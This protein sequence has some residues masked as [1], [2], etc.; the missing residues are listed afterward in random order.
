[1]AASTVTPTAPVA[2]FPL[3]RLMKIEPVRVQEK[4]KEGNVVIVAGFQGL[5]PTQDIATLGR[6]GSD[7][8]AVALAAALKAERCQIFTDVEGVYTTDPRIVEVARKLDEIA[9]D[10][11]LELAS[12]GAKVLQSRSVEFAKKY[13]VVVEV[14]SSFNNKPGTLVREEVKH[15]EE[16]TA[17]NHF[18][19]RFM[20]S[21]KRGF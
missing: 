19:E 11:M 2:V 7:L 6:G 12:L 9:Y 15:M 20:Y 17:N 8:T 10:E 21:G 16:K 14:L 1:M 3:I 18:V 4:L 13:G 5:A